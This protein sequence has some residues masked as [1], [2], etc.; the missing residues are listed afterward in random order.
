VVTT[1]LQKERFEDIRSFERYLTRN[2]IVILKFFLNLSKK[3]QKKRFLARLDHPEKNWKF[4]AADIDERSFWSDY[5]DAYEDMI[6]H[7][8]TDEAPW[9]VVPADNKWFTRIAVASAI[10]D[11]LEEL[12]LA[13]PKVSDAKKKELADAR[14]LLESKK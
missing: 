11:A 6:R 14:K 5:M 3:E 12:D 1:S 8:A 9:H 2:G 13:Y 7:T 4:S 10:V